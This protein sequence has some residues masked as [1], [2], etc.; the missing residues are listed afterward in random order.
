MFFAHRINVAGYSRKL[1][2]LTVSFLGVSATFYF[3]FHVFHGDRGLIAWLQLRQQ[4]TVASTT[5][6]SVH[7][8][9]TYLESRVRLLHPTSLDPD[10][11]DERARLMLNFGHPDEIIILTPPHIPTHASTT[12]TSPEGEAMPARETSNPKIN[13]NFT[14]NL[15]GNNPDRSQP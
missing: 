14:T 6:T 4:V 12:F 2:R 3:V 11:L 9:R 15:S 5:A 7:G 8:K 13:V 1:R 10:M